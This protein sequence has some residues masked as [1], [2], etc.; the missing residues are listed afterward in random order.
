MSNILVITQD[1]KKLYNCTNTLEN[2]G[3]CVLFTQGNQNLILAQ[4]QEFSPD[5][6]IIDTKFEDT[7][8]ITKKI[9][10]DFNDLNTQIILV[11]AA[12]DEPNYLDWAD[13]FILEPINENILIST[14]KSH[15]KI[16]NSLDEL[17]K[18]NKEIS[19]NLY[20][21]N[22]LYNTSTKFAGTL[23]REKLY[24]IMLEG[25]EKTLSFDV[26]TLLVT[27]KEKKSKIYINSL[28]ETTESL[29]EALQ[30]RLLLCY[31][32]IQ[33]DKT[34]F[35]INLKNIDLIQN[36]RPTRQIFDLK[37]FNFD[38]ISA[39][40]KV[41]DDFFGII[42]IYRQKPFTAEDKTCFQTITNQIPLPLRSAK[43]Y[44]EI[45]EK[46]NILEKLEKIKS[47]FVSI[48]SHELRTPLTPINNSLEIILSGQA[49]EITE[50]TRN[51]INMAKRN[52]VRLGEIIEDLLDLSRVQTGKMDIEFKEI[53]LNPAL[54][55]AKETF[56]QS[57]NKKNIE[58]EFITEDNLP[59]IYADN[60]RI[61]QILSNLITNAIKFTPNDGK[62]T[63]ETKKISSNEID[64]DKLIAPKTRIINDYIKISVKDTGVGIEEE[65]IVKI[66]DK[67]SQIE[68]TLSRKVGGIGLGLSIAKHLIDS[69]LGAISV[70]SEKDK[71]A[72]FT[73]YIPILSDVIKFQIDVVKKLNGAKNNT[74]I[75]IKE[76]ENGGF[77][78]KIKE[79]NLLKTTNK[80]LS[81]N[82]IDENYSHTWLFTP[83]LERNVLD[84]SEKAILGEIEKNYTE[85]EKCDIVFKKGDFGQVETIET[86]NLINKIWEKKIG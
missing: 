25:L 61:G 60:K 22:A 71:G 37:V 35:E 17:D 50:N 83:D 27:Y 8:L 30:L 19:K 73:V 72:N 26:A 6:I 75:Y 59:K 64:F 34:P 2:S 40:I 38:K 20:S 42:E 24:E 39:P 49:G 7:E 51:F 43:L 70:I 29:K 85:A 55:L 54:E 11:I 1:G 9:K 68:N 45:I 16:K 65:N 67:F 66:F 56:T 78:N 44:E 14:I 18:N 21:L 86:Y 15:L 53:E 36:T 31:K 79:N 46:N 63:V 12:F 4:I 58:L 81:L 41:G 82:L 28:H 47:E 48:V 5:I 69:H 74:L 10:S 33:N 57:A 52:M 13:G 3:H 32:N 84:F 77:L 62:I 23:D 80:T 76:K